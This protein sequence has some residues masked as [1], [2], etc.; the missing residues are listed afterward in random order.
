MAKRSPKTIM[1]NRE[2]KSTKLAKFTRKRNGVHDSRTKEEMGI[3]RQKLNCAPCP[4]SFNPNQ[5]KTKID[6]KHGKSV[7]TAKK[8]SICISELKCAAWNI[9]RGLIT[10]EGEL[11]NL[12]NAEDIDII[13]LSETDTKSLRTEEDY[14]IKGYNAIFH[15]RKD[16][17]SILRLVCLVKTE[18]RKNITIRSDLMSDS[19]PSIWIEQ[20]QYHVVLMPTCLVGRDLG[21]G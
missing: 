16:E 3:P 19:F 21:F 11:I 12:L 5:M 2:F 18:I 7:K 14:Y 17:V 6:E 4:K 1:Y 10:R 9:N 13:F 20:Q 15:K 8:E